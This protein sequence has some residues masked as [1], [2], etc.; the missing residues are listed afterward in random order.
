M[1]LAIADMSPSV[2]FIS[3]TATVP[4]PTRIADGV[5]QNRVM[6]PPSDIDHTTKAK[7]SRVPM[8]V[9]RSMGICWM[10]GPPWSSP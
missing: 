5:S 7:Q 1:T 8:R 10:I 4:P 2:K 3:T 9:L 6:S